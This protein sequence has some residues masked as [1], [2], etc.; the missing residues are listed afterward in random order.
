MITHGTNFENNIVF[1]NTY[2]TRVQLAKHCYA[3]QSSYL[4][5]WVYHS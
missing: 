5:F 4:I 2:D 1:F 3:K